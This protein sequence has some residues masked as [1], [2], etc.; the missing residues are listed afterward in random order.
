LQKF[1]RTTP[2]PDGHTHLAFVN[3]GRGYFSTSFDAGHSHQG[4]WIPAVPEQP[5]QQDPNT[6]EIIPAVPAQPCTPLK[7][8]VAISEFPES[9]PEY[10]EIQ[11]D[12]VELHVSMLLLVTSEKFPTAS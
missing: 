3:E 1:Q 6:G 10:P 12:V 2:A 7:L 11:D 8:I 4:Q 5:E 9:V